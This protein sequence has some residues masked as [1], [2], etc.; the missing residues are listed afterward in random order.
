M[1]YHRMNATENSVTGI[2]VTNWNRLPITQK[3][4]ESLVANTVPKHRTVVIDNGTTDDFDI[5]DGVEVYRAYKYSPTTHEFL[6]SLLEN[7]SITYVLR[8]AR[9]YGL[10]FARNV[11]VSILNTQCDYLSF[12]KP[13]FLLISDS[14]I[15]YPEGW[16]EHTYSLWNDISIPYNLGAIMFSNCPEHMVRSVI[17]YGDKTLFI[18]NPCAGNAIFLPTDLFLELGQFPHNMVIGNEDWELC[19]KLKEANLNILNCEYL[20]QHIG[21]RHSLW[22]GAGK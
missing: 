18:K 12:K 5:I 6:G 14:D 15:F 7:G 9:N 10:G 22:L 2:V 11:G 1:L 4:L 8:D 19:R 17:E 3:S 21:K 16:L 20:L 13:E